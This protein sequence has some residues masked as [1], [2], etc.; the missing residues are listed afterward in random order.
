MFSIREYQPCLN[1]SCRSNLILE[2]DKL[3]FGISWFIRI[4]ELPVSSKSSFKYLI[5]TEWT[6]SSI[7]RVHKS[8]Y[9]LIVNVFLF[10][11][12]NVTTYFIRYFCI[13]CSPVIYWRVNSLQETIARQTIELTFEPFF[14]WTANFKTSKISKN[15]KIS[16]ISK[17]FKISKIFK[18]F[19]NFKRIFF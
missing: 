7:E 8:F 16:K 14:H 6:F 15:F 2:I 17:Y 10:I 3:E 1:W 18:K 13:F 4:L 12:Y 9:Y 5:Q 19:Q 11:K